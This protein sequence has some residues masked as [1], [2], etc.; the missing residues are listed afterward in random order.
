MQKQID[1]WAPRAYA[2]ICN[3]LLPLGFIALL[4][5]LAV[6]PERSYYHKSFY[7]LIAI[8]TLLALTIRPHASKPL[9]LHPIIIT[10][11]MFSLWALL[12]ISWSDT[13]A[14]LSSL[15]KRPLYILMLFAACALMAL[16][17]NQ[18]LALSTLLAALFILPITG[19]SLAEFI[20]SGTSGNRFVGTGALDNPLLSSHLF[21]F[22][23]ALWLALGMTLPPRQSGFAFLAASLLGFAMLATGSRTPL[24]ATALTCTWLI[25]TCWNKRSA[26]L[27]VSGALGVVAL[28]LL[29]PELLASRGLS[30][31]P[32]L[33]S[34][35]LSKISQQP[36]HGFGFDAHLG[37]YIAELATTF[38][39][40]H[41]FALGVLYYTGIVGLILWLTV[42]GLALFECWK[43]KSNFLFIVC[44]A[45][46]V[47]GIGAG[48]TE[49]GGILARPKEHWLVSWIPLALIAALSIRTRQAQKAKY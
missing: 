37:L 48:L 32:E 17:S 22:F 7:A 29:N 14:S 45:L 31:R 34:Q 23:C 20:A 26:W 43:Y 40:P 19:Y 24:V 1:S 18:R 9:W 42:H 5:G 15:L 21:G 39:E 6:W 4:I 47:Y 28:A 36:W 27:L 11:L 46:L 3:W 25:T 44:G 33:W 30:Y 35:T 49:G 16:Q 38:S 12:S 2:F 8:P 13:D 10:F 41:S